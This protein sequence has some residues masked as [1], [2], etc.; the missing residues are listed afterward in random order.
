MDSMGRGSL[1]GRVAFHCFQWVMMIFYFVNQG[2]SS[3]CP[4]LGMYIEDPWDWYIYLHLVDFYGKCRDIYHTW[5]L[6]VII[7]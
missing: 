5:I 6:R 7:L 1:L 3:A 2:S 4:F